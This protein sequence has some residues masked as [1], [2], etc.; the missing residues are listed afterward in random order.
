VFFSLA[1]FLSSV[2]GDVWRPLLIALGTAA[3]LA[4]G[5]QFV[6]VLSDHGLIATMSGQKY[7]RGGGLPWTGLAVS[8]ALSAAML[9]GAVRNLARR[10]F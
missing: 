10:D 3:L 1:F 7:F 5:E 6:D 4:L 9:H 8:A 2:F